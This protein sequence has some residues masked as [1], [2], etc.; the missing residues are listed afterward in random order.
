MRKRLATLLVS[1]TLLS[2]A[3]A[4]LL[5]HVGLKSSSPAAGAHLAQVPKQL[6]LDFTETLELNF[7]LL[8]LMLATGREI[9]LGPLAYAPDSR[10]ALIAP[11]VGAMD[12]GTYTVMWQVA[13]DDGHPVRGRFEF[14]VAPGAMGTSAAPGGMSGMHHDPVTMPEGSGFGAESPLYVFIRWVQF[15]ALL[16]IIGAVSFHYFVLGR[17]QRD[18]ASDGGRAEPAFL[19]DAERDAASVGHVAAAVLAATLV[20][21][22]VAQ[23]Y[24][25]HGAEGVFDVSLA[26]AMI[27]KTMWGWGWL[28]QLA[29]LV[30]AGVGFHLARNSSREVFQSGRKGRRT[31]A[32]WW[33]L[34]AAGAVLTAFSPAF[35]GHAASVPKLRTLAIVNDGLHVLGASSWLGT[36]TVVLIAGLG[37][38]TRQP[39]GTGGQL[40]RVLINA[41]SPIALASAGLAAVTGVF[42]AWLHVGTIPNLWGTRYGIT[43]L[44][45]L[46]ILS[47]V[48]LS[49]FYN[50]RVVQPRLGTD[51]ATT[52]LRRSARVEVGV[53]VLVLFVTAILVASPTSMDATM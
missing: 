26:G 5:A 18:V 37:V 44:V 43:L 53:A 47:I 24:A 30:L 19:A 51:A 23:S 27:R 15:T 20:V 25:M 46:A 40:V 29:G 11:V 33:R 31:T 21:R 45:K 12:A 50:W 8:R 36:L 34:A 52:R 6:R 42:A 22:L 48:V 38:A 7:A 28:L 2:A 13:G 4:P 39:P 32:K 16:L 1:A 35:S 3:P 49:G 41:F 14:V 9:P 10:R 17:V